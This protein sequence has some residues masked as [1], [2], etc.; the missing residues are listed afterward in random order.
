M[1]FGQGEIFSMIYRM[2]LFIGIL[3]LFTLWALKPSVTESE[4]WWLWVV[5]DVTDIQ[6]AAPSDVL[7]GVREN[8]SVAL[9]R[10][11]GGK[12]L[13]STFVLEGW[14]WL[15]GDSLEALR[16]GGVL[17]VGIVAAVLVRIGTRRT[18]TLMLRVMIF[19]LVLFPSLAFIQPPDVISHELL[20]FQSQRSSPRDTV[21]TLFSDSSPLGYYHH[22]YQLRAGM[23]IDLGWRDFS[24]EEVIHIADKLDKSRPI[25]LISPR[26]DH[27]ALYTLVGYLTQN[28]RQIPFSMNW[29]DQLAILRF[30]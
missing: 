17:L 4:A 2:Q 23:G 18:A 29:N 15:A 21:I 8:L 22:R 25:W 30:E 19:L 6:P 13:P 26:Y 28:G 9:D 27:P 3:L 7:R 24:P 14:T 1:R 11:G 5:R 10:S 12:N 20:A 16:W